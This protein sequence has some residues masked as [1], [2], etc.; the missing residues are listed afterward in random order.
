VKFTVSAV[1][2]GENDTYDIVHD[3]NVPDKAV[4][5]RYKMI[6]VSQFEWEINI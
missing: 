2:T 3:I 4:H 6:T 1:F 5:A